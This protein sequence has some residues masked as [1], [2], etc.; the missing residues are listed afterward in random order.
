M[1]LGF[2]V[3]I[4]HYYI[5]LLVWPM[6]KCELL[7]TILQHILNCPQLFISHLAVTAFFLPC[8]PQTC[9][10][11]QLPHSH[12]PN[13]QHK[14]RHTLQL[15]Q[16]NIH[17]GMQGQMGQNPIIPRTHA[18][19]VVPNPPTLPTFL[20]SASFMHLL[21]II[22]VIGIWGSLLSINLGW[23]WSTGSKALVGRHS[24]IAWKILF[25]KPD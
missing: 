2:I 7:I 10:F 22:V 3:F 14:E 15:I 16:N 21:I 20:W 25:V 23:T 17:A 1:D 4:F 12:P 18:V 5:Y 6:Q 13:W 8:P 11:S 19:Q 9:R 24:E